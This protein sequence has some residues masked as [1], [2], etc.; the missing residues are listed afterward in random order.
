MNEGV[1]LG[2][3]SNVFKCNLGGGCRECGGLGVVWDNTDYSDFGDFCQQQDT[4]L[5]VLRQIKLQGELACVDADGPFYR[6][7]G[8]KPATKEVWQFPRHLMS[9]VDDA[10]AALPTLPQ[11]TR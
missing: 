2:E 10:L 1:P 11:T 4:A 8:K 3:W 6:S 9:A 5:D 7:G